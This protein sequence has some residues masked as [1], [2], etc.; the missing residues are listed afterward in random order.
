MHRRENTSPDDVGDGAMR[1]LAQA[2]TAAPGGGA[3]VLRDLVANWGPEDEIV[4]MC[5]RGDVAETIRDAGVEVDQ[6]AARSTAEALLRVSIDRSLVRRHLPDVVW[7]Q[8]VRVPFDGPQVLHLR[9]IGVFDGTHRATPRERVRRMRI[10]NDVRRVDRSVANSATMAAAVRASSRCLSEVPL[11]VVPNGLDLAAFIEVAPPISTQGRDLRIL[12][13]QSDHPH[14]RSDL[15]AEVLAHVLLGL[16][17]AFTDARLLVP[18]GSPHLQLRR[19]LDEHGLTGNADFIG[20]VSR[21]EMAALYASCDVVLLTSSTE[22]FCNP[23]IEAAAAGR[24]LISTPLPV[25]RETGGPMALIARSAAPED[26]ADVVLR[27]AA[28][29]SDDVV[30]DQARCHALRF[31]ARKSADALRRVL[32][33]ACQEAKRH[34]FPT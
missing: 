11:D 28:I 4:V 13:P 16:P 29:G 15:A 24:W 25:L 8:G 9:D 22:S 34:S 27:V 26:L 2:I 18:G 19:A 17:E 21:T 5:W 7:S 12:L 20:R 10:R 1:I 14:K 30:R 3:T 32:Q 31:T 6:I 23:A 33:D